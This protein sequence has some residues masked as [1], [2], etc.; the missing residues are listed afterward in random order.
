MPKHELSKAMEHDIKDS[1][2]N[3]HD[4]GTNNLNDVSATGREAMDVDGPD[5]ESI[6]H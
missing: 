3:N 6:N 1:N 2:D 5:N 4:T